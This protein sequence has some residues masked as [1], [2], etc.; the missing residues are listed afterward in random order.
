MNID[1]ENRLNLQPSD[2]VGQ[3]IVVLGTSGSGKSNT[4]AVLLEELLPHFP[5]TI[6]DP[7]GEYWGLREQYQMLLVG[8][9]E[10]ADVKVEAHNAGA[11]AALSF[12]ERVPVILDFSESRAN[13]MMAFLVAYFEMLWEITSPE[14]ARKAYGLLFEEARVFAPQG[15]PTPV[16]PL[17][18]DIATRGRKRGL[19]TILVSQRATGVDKDLLTQAKFFFLHQSAFPTDT[20][21]YMDIVPRQ[22]ADV[23]R[24]VDALLV[25]EAIYRHERTVEFVQLR[26]RHT[27][28]TGSTPT[29]GE[30]APV[31]KSISAKLLMSLRSQLKDKP[32]DERETLRQENTALKTELKTQAETIREL[33]AQLKAQ[34]KPEKVVQ[35]ALQTK[36]VQPKPIS[37]KPPSTNTAS[38]E[39]FLSTLHSVHVR[40]LAYTVDQRDRWVGLRE[41][42][43]AFSYAESS[44]MK[45][46]PVQLINMELLE[47]RGQGLMTEYRAT[48]DKGLQ[49][50]FPHLRRNDV[51]S[52]L[53]RNLK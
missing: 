26:L 19:T 15:K 23:Q 51:E 28:H 53:K 42:K 14:A 20:E 16:K 4:A 22:R 27:F 17:L 30:N 10:R 1:T 43:R 33:K 8:N 46:P 34:Q 7:D 31:Q 35:Q 52:V 40:V 45:N 6:V 32:V 50:H 9:M 44:L 21:V 5:F 39:R 12:H 25:G 18:V 37:I 49:T 3:R 29:L 2:L 48:L 24:M 11:I 38:F 41:L 47:R 36:A 13:E